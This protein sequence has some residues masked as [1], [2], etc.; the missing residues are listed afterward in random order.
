MRKI[1]ANVV[2]RILENGQKQHRVHISSDLLRNAE[3]YD[4]VIIGDETLCF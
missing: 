2:P 3:M 1:S 4:T